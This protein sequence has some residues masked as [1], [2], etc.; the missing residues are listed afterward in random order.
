MFGVIAVVKEQPVIDLSVATHA[1]CD[2]LVGVRSVVPVIAIQ[3]TETM[4]EVLIKQDK[5]D[6]AIRIYEKLSLLNPSKR[7]YFAAKIEQL[8]GI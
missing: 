5:N 3:V 1:P 8:K 6:E 7:A 2:W 4:A